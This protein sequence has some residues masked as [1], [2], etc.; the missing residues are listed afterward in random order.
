MS[1]M[2]KLLLVEDDAFLGKLLRDKF[3]LHS[4]PVVFVDDGNDVFEKAKTEKPDLIV[5]DISLPHKGGFEILSEL[6]N[7]PGTKEIPVII[8]TNLSQDEDRA[9]GIQL[10]AK[11]YI[12]KYSTHIDDFIQHILDILGDKK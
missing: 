1:T 2:G 3:T 5:L 11:E 7:D 12:P 6:K 10:G 4:V 8:F 9:K